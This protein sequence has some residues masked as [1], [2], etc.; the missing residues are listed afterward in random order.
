MDWVHRQ[1]IKNEGLTH[2]H[3]NGLHLD[4]PMR[5]ALLIWTGP[6]SLGWMLSAHDHWC[7]LSWSFFL[8]MSPNVGDG[9][10]EAT[11]GGGRRACASLAPK[12]QCDNP[13]TSG[14]RS[15]GRGP[16]VR[17]GPVKD[18]LARTDRTT[19]RH[20]NLISDAFRRTIDGEPKRTWRGVNRTRSTVG[21]VWWC[22]A[23]RR[24]GTFVEESPAVWSRK[25]F[26]ALAAIW[27]FEKAPVDI[28]QSSNR[29]RRSS[30]VG[31]GGGS[32]GLRRPSRGHR[33]ESVPRQN[34]ERGDS[35]KAASTLAL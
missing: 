7:F 4:T 29:D 14:N 3:D 19:Q 24:D 15:R 17:N 28:G 23:S 26:H 1:Q 20:D 2:R 18:D 9:R 10:T 21:P 31:G 16:Y 30:S 13:R 5:Y 27:S 8:D 34:S 11:R 22:T 35:N 33:T 12:S 6:I 32:N 25:L